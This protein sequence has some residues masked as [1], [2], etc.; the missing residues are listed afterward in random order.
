MQAE[1]P[2]QELVTLCERH[3]F[4]RSRKGFRWPEEI[5]TR[6]LSNV[7]SGRSVVEVSRATGIRE[8]TIYSWQAELKK[9]KKSSAFREIA[10]SSQAA[11]SSLSKDHEIVLKNGECELKLVRLTPEELREVIRQVIIR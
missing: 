7:K 4:D 8:K 5:K 6:V 1:N 3:G 2:L 10:I 9:A 11:T